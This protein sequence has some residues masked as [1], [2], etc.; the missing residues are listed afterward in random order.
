MADPLDV[1]GNFEELSHREIRV[2]RIEN[3]K[4]V[5]R[6]QPLAP[7]PVN[8]NTL[9]YSTGRIPA[10][11]MYVRYQYARA[12][13][14]LQVVYVQEKLPGASLSCWYT[15]GDAPS[16]HSARACLTMQNHLHHVSRK[17]QS[18][19]KNFC[20]F[21]MKGQLLPLLMISKISHFLLFC[22]EFAIKENLLFLV[23]TNW[24]HS[25]KRFELNQRKLFV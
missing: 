23:D 4:Q 21:C 14:R 3:R 7:I 16:R 13:Y 11:P 20:D 19:S 10:P 6:K 12:S 15:Q 18:L 8:S 5:L 2:P 1:P 22:I 25:E 9:H 24:L 17:N